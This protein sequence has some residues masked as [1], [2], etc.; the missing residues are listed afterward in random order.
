MALGYPATKTAREYRNGGIIWFGLH[1]G[2]G[3]KRSEEF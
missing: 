1:Y 2:I 3:D